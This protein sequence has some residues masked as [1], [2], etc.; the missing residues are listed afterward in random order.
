MTLREGR[1]VT[2]VSW[3]AHDQEA[4]AAAEQ[5]AADNVEAEVIDVATLKPLDM[6]TILDS[7]GGPAAGHRA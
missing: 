7:V 4:L 1:D 6:A 2:L 3:G 5:L